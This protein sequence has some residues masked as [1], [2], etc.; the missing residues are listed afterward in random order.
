MY[1]LGQIVTQVPGVLSRRI[2]PRAG[3][4][5]TWGTIH[6][7]QAPNAIPDVG[8]LAGTLRCMDVNAWRSAAALVVEAI[9][10]VARPYTVQVE[11]DH[12]PGLP[13]VMN[14]EEA[15]SHAFAAAR[16]LVG[17]ERVVTAE[18]SLG[19]ED[20]AWYLTEVPGALLRLGTR[21]PGGT[22]YDLHRGDIVFDERAIGI[23]ARLLALT[24]LRAAASL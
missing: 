13:P 4:N 21:T 14:D 22:T 15:L 10:E 7:G 24:A 16:D 18:Q 20:F 2:D 6:A 11:V 1:A 19:G 3:L 9:H 23:G 12:V 5:L 8:T 17:E